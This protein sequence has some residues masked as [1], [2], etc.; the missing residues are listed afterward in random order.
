M[1]EEK[2]MSNQE[3]INPIENLFDFGT[4]SS[5]DQL[6]E[7]SNLSEQKE[8]SVV[9]GVVIEKTDAGAVVDF[10]FKAE[11]FLPKEEF[12]DWDELKVGDEVEAV[13][14]AVEGEDGEPVL[15]VEKARFEAAWR[16]FLSEVE[17]GQV[18]KGYIKRRV[19]GGLMV[20]IGVEAFLPGSQL[21]AAPVRNLDDFI[22]KE[23]DFKV[24]KINEAR[25][26]VVVSRRELIEE[27]KRLMR[28]ELLENIKP[29]DLRKGIVKNITDFG[30]FVDLHGID[31]LI[32]IT[33]M[34]WG[35]I[36]HPSEL[37][38]VGQEIETV[39]LD[40]DQE[41]ERVSLGLKQKTEDPWEKVEERYPVGS[42]VKGVVVNVVPYGAFVEIEKGIEGLIHVSEMSWT[43][44]IVK[45]SEV[46][47]VGE[48]VEVVVLD[49]QK[50]NKKISLGL[51]QTQENPWEVAAAK[52]P[53]GTKVKG[54]VRNMTSYGAFIE[55]EPN[56]DGMVHIS[57][58]SWTRKVNNPAEVLNK[59]DEV[60]AVV[61]EVNPEQQRISLSIKDLTRD[62]WENIEDYYKVGD[63]VKGRVTKVTSFGAFVELDYGIDGLIHISQVSDKRI[64]KVREVLDVG[65]EV[66]A[67][68][69]KVDTEERRIGLSMKSDP[70]AK[71]EPSSSRKRSSA[72]TQES[73][74]G[75]MASREMVDMG[76]LLEDAFEELDGLE[77]NRESSDAQKE[78]SEK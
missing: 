19:K 33:D 14:E 74:S 77:L 73:R 50:E 38:E 4:G 5:M 21:D 36:S 12:R 15:S 40:V 51:R 20:D 35:R 23:F 78:E 76:D 67:Y 64:G 63:K 26:N 11:A 30:V 43:R 39:I 9:K 16:K 46:L 58:M 68:V 17:E 22:G 65:E 75:S 48:E 57:D 31:G 13:L 32:H 59:G 55:I 2:Q 66:E 71:P 62:P 37:V 24:L 45:A 41:K 44:K 56:I 70:F 69:I 10:N 25:R 29:G 34:S 49:I 6:L 18:V 72:K 1:L 7:D 60:E 52:Y 54:R 42:R 61:L 27:E 3:P 8:S 28:K 53:P 47:H